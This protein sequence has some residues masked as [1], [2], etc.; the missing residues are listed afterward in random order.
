MDLGFGPRLSRVAAGVCF[1]LFVGGLEY[2]FGIW[3][4]LCIVLLPLLL[5]LLFAVTLPNDSGKKRTIGSAVSSVDV[6]RFFMEWLDDR[7]ENI[8]N[9]IKRR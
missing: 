1:I 9:L 2:L 6:G 7:F 5:A 3:I 8:G 4:V